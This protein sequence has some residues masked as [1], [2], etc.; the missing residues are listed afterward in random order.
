MNDVIY[1]VIFRMA[2]DG[3]SVRQAIQDAPVSRST[4]YN[5]RRDNLDLYTTIEEQAKADAAGIRR[6]MELRVASQRLFEQQTLEL[7]LVKEMDA[8]ADVVIALAKSAESDATKLSA[9]KTVRQ[10]IRD[11]VLVR[12]ESTED[13]DFAAVTVLPPVFNPHTDTLLGRIDLPPGTKVEITTPEPALEQ[14]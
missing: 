5:W 4:F 8:I 10:W 2:L 12:R 7:K 14:A 1:R 13:D 11:G 6:E 3:R 9:A